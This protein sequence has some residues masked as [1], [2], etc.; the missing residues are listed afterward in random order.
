MKRM[1]AVAQHG[2]SQIW[3][4]EIHRLASPCSLGIYIDTLARNSVQSRRRP[5]NAMKKKGPVG[6]RYGAYTNKI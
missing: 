6:Y 3:H 1:L 4:G 2:K 5:K